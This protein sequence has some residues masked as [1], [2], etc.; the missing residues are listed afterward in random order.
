MGKKIII[1]KIKA[2]KVTHIIIEGILYDYLFFTKSEILKMDIVFIINSW[3]IFGRKYKKVSSLLK[4][5][6]EEIIFSE[7]DENLPAIIVFTG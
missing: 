2:A 6:K 1:E 5:N 7:T 4:E 3:S